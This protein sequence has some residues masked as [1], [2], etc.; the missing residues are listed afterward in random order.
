MP[1]GYRHLT[2]YER[3]QIGAL[4]ESGLS[5]GAIAARLGRDRTTVWRELRRNAGDGGYSPGEA[6]GKAEAAPLKPPPARMAAP[7]GVEWISRSRP[8]GRREGAA[9]PEPGRT[10][11]APAEALRRPESPDNLH[12]EG[13]TA[14]PGLD[15][16]PPGGRKPRL[17]AIPSARATPPLR[18]WPVLHFGMEVG[19]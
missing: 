9:R 3:C 18:E 11:P 4:K 15:P 12:T 2:R 17:P 13:T 14:V 16:R 6:Q 10:R 7:G 1:K 8:S 19:I 5:D